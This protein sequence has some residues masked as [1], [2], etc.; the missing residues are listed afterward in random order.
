MPALLVKNHLQKETS[1]YLLQHMDNPVEWYPW[2]EKA[3]ARAR[4][5]DKPILLSIG[6]SACHWC[7]VMA[8]ESFENAD[9]A[10]MMNDYFINIKV[11]REERPDLDQ[12]YQLAQQMLTAR[13]G[14]WP[15]TMFLEPTNQ[16]PFFGG[17]Y[18]P[19][20]GRY[21]LPGFKDLLQRIAEYFRTH[22]TEIHSQNSQLLAAFRDSHRQDS[23]KVL[24]ITPLK[25]AQQQLTQSFDSDYGGLKGAPK[26][27]NPTI[28]ERYLRDVKGEYLGDE[29][30]QQALAKMKLTLDHI[31]QG[32]IYDQ[33]GGGF[34][35]YSVDTKWQ[36]PHFEKMLYDNGQL[37]T[38]Y[39]DA[40]RLCKDKLYHQVLIEMGHWIKREMQSSKG[41][42]YSSLDADSEGHEG[43]F[44]VWTQDQVRLILD[45]DEYFLAARYF[46]FDQS[47]N[48]EGQWHL[49][50]N[51]TIKIL[52]QEQDLPIDK[53]QEKLEVVRQKLF[54]ARES[55]VRPSRDDKILTAWNA[56]VIKGMATAG[57]VLNQGNFITSAEQ[58]LN[59]IR[60]HLW[61]D[62]RLLVSYKDGRA[63]HRGYLDD[64]A[65]LIDALLTLLQT[66]WQD[67][68][69]IFAVQ[70]TDVVLNHFEDKSQGA[71][72]FTADDHETLIHRP[73]P[74]MD[75]ATPAG[76]GVMALNLI[77]LGHLL[78]EMR[79]LEAAERSLKASWSSIQRTP[80]AH[81][82]L[83]KALEE[84]CYPPQI[85]ILRG[86][87]EALKSWQ[88][89]ATASYDPKRITLAIPIEAQGLLGQLKKY[90]P[91]GK[92][93]TAYICS[94]QTCSAPITHI[95]S[96]KKQLVY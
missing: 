31:A 22:R 89:I 17:T 13:P 33:L 5:E 40:Y 91:I 10:A 6:Y 25:L 18:F 30:Q 41:G 46:G 93:V 81:C 12:I 63:Q 94:G 9:T 51:T 67:E 78:G 64:Y 32:G 47:A 52:A 20:E 45:K 14:G 54:I 68:D 36:I 82:S 24:N 62:G 90:N 27:P 75:N 21:G 85:I 86:S 74:L 23:A 76:N 58:A 72:Y 59:F 55:R 49:C 50:L 44:Y 38:L 71:F 8:H 73:I 48:F 60:N 96:F 95:E 3:L 28:I 83:L 16:A 53:V 66:R 57:Q 37:L 70:L 65:F 69:L 7:H 19:P 43:K 34:Y 26:F 61:Q 87:Q 35:R 88:D 4:R 79:Y 77:R 15:L 80:H 1:P 84:W 2:G 92:S 42:Y 56:L 39:A 29:S 11:D